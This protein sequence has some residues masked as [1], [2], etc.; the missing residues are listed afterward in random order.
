MRTEDK[1]RLL[2]NFID[3]FTARL[4]R[5]NL[6][7]LL[8]MLAVIVWTATLSFIFLDAA[9]GINPMHAYYYR[10]CVIAAASLFGAAYYYRRIHKRPGHAAAAGHIEKLDPCNNYLS[11]SVE[12]SAGEIEKY[13]FSE[14]LYERT[15]ESAAD[16][17]LKKDAGIYI[18]YSLVKKL[19]YVAGILAIATIVIFSRDGGLK[20]L[21]KIWP[22][23]AGL[24]MPAPLEITSRNR[25][26]TAFVDEEIDFSFGFSRSEPAELYI[27]YSADGQKNPFQQIDFDNPE[28]ASDTRVYKLTPSAAK[29][30]RGFEYGLKL[31]APSYNFYYRARSLVSD[32][33]SATYFVSSKRRPEILKVNAAYEFPKYTRIAPMIEENATAISGLYMS[34]VKL[35]AHSSAPL[36]GAKLIFADNRSADMD[37]ML[38]GRAA[39][40]KFRLVKKDAYKIE[41][42]DLE[43]IKSRGG[44]FHDISVYEDK[45]PSCEIIEPAGVINAPYDRKADVTIKARDD[46]AISKLVLVYYKNEND[47]ESREI[48]LH[49]TSS[50]EIFEKTVLDFNFMN[51]KAGEALFYYA[52][53]FD[54]DDISGPKSTRS[55]VNKIV[56]PTQFDEAMELEALYGSIETRLE[57][58]TGDQKAIAEKIEKMDALQ[59]QGAMND[60]EMKKNFENI[61]RNQ[62]NLMNEAKELASDL[63]EALKKM[64]NNIYIKPETLAKISEIQ[65]KIE[66]MVSEDMKRLMGDINKNVEKTKLSADDVKKMSQNF[67]EKKLV[68]KFERL[69]ELFSKAEKEQKLSTFMKELEFILSKQEFIAE[70]TEKAAP[71]NTELNA[72]LAREQK[73]AAENYDKALANFEKNIGDISEISDEIKKAAGEALESLKTDDVG[74]RMKKAGDG[75]EKNDPGKAFDEQKQAAE[76]MKKNLDALKKA[77]DEFKEKNKK[78]LL[79]AISKLIKRAIAMSA[80]EMDIIREFE[81]VRGLMKPATND[82]FVQTLDA[83][84]EKCLEISNVS[85]EIAAELTRL[86]KKTI[87]IDSNNIAVAGAIVRQFSQIKPML[88]EREFTNAANLSAQIYYNISILNM[89]LLDIFDIL[90]SSKSGSNMDQLMSMIKKQAEAQARL[91]AKTKDMMKKAGENGMPQLSDDAL[92]T[93][94][95]E[96]QMIRRS[97]ERMMEAMDGDSEPARRLRE[98]RSEMQNLEVEYMRKKVDAK[99]QSRQKILHERLLDMQQALFKEK[100][101]TERKAERAK[102]YAPASPAAAIETRKVEQRELKLDESLKNEKYPKSFEKIIELYFD[103]VKKF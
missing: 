75:L 98:L 6:I 85:R 10:A 60:Y 88:A 86:S 52:I 87:L 94:A 7:K 29:D 72:E 70:N 100:E 55:A 80:F 2:L 54:N 45:Y 15:L 19:L 28:G 17:Y 96:Q 26:F 18:D 3:G 59:K 73:L 50:A 23:I 47:E 78:D 56:F 27:R 99:V 35:I 92:K 13:G 83:I 38:D 84:S 48:T 97:L 39:A 33:F 90:T 36:S 8:L 34:E 101:T 71:E 11:T 43:G 91:N 61:A 30:G 53:A 41:L 1:R 64:E 77:F 67:D 16:H 58:I 62:Q 68:E 24:F 32:S 21:N 49:E 51:F 4:V 89:M 69:K 95:F 31:P 20:R 74:G 102:K 9:F 42:T 44:N 25:D 103:A 82:R 57:K 22:E 76:S 46:F 63:K 5:L 65:E 93:L 79:E 66:K 14:P 37:V 12:I 40:A 81:R